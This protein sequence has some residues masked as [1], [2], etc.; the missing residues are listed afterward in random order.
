[1]DVGASASLF[2]ADKAANAAAKAKADKVKKLGNT[3][4]KKQDY[5]QAI[6]FYSEAIGT[7]SFISKFIR[8][9]R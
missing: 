2:Q 9:L 4:Y 7:P 1:M 6:D 8:N 5:E 3:Y